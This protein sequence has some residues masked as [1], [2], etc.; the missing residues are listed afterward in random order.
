[1]VLFGMPCRLRSYTLSASWLSDPSISLVLLL[2]DG[3]TACARSNRNSGHTS[4]LQR[5]HKKVLS[6]WFLIGK[7]GI[8]RQFRR[9]RCNWQPQ[10]ASFRGLTK[11]FRKFSFLLKDTH[12]FT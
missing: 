3:A 11:D 9:L 8:L 10:L 12:T 2:D 6:R 4:K 5:K 1:M 7:K